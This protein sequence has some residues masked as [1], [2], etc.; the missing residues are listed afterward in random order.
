MDV[1]R[2]LTGR[3]DQSR[4]SLEVIASA[5]ETLSMLLLRINFFLSF[6]LDVCRIFTTIEINSLLRLQFRRVKWDRTFSSA[7]ERIEDITDRQLSFSLGS[8]KQHSSRTWYLDA[9]IAF[10]VCS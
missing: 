9:L 4:V 2:L 3:V 8:V 6:S 5:L 7:G 1:S 10:T